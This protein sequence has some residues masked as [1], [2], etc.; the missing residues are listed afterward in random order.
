MKINDTYS[1]LNL[2]S[3]KVILSSV[4]TIEIEGIKYFELFN[5]DDSKHRL[6]SHSKWNEGDK[7]YI[8]DNDLLTIQVLQ[9]NN[10]GTPTE[11]YQ[12]WVPVYVISKNQVI[13]YN[14]LGNYFRVLR[15]D[16]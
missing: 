15:E 8:K 16:E 13:N 4:P 3:K 5:E 2:Q 11:E 12:Y 14:I 10:S 7:I 1:F 6:S 9:V